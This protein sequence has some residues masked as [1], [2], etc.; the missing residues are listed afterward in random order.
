MDIN[1]KNIDF[2]Q[3]EE[4]DISGAM[5]LVLAEN[6]NQTKEDWQMFQELNSNL[7][8]VA[9]Y[10]GTIIGT[11]TAINFKDQVAWI[12]MM[13]VSKNFRGMGI[14]KYLLKTIIDKLEGCRTIKLDA[15]AAGI[16]VYRK[17]GFQEDF[18]INRMVTTNFIG[19]TKGE[20]INTVKPI[21]LGDMEEILKFDINIFGTDRSDLINSL[22]NR[23]VDNAWCIVRDERIV[24]Y[25]LG[26][27][28]LN[29]FQ[30]GPLIAETPVDAINLME[31]ILEQFVGQPLVIDV[32]HD[33]VEL[34][35]R[36]ACLGFSYQRSFIRMY[37][38]ENL[39]AGCVNKQFLIAGPELG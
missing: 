9:T 37:L 6:W 38:K 30:L 18:E 29:F 3:M 25:A 10:N 24:G 19:D 35:T 4:A 22:I 14:S 33:Q 27:P 28:G 16:P 8:L 11:V 23:T 39:Y 34:K 36:L 20:N 12:G 7:C 32:L 21:S 15:T 31:V 5:Q 26:R 2:R 1:L 13:L 17:L